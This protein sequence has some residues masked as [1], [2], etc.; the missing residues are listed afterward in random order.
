MRSLPDYAEMDI[1]SGRMARLSAAD[2]RDL[3]DAMGDR[4]LTVSSNHLRAGFFGGE[5]RKPPR[6]AE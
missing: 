3:L 5:R 6:G 2:D 4:W 1:A